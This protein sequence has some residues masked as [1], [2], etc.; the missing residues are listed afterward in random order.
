MWRQLFRGIPAAWHDLYES[1]EAQK[2]IEGYGLEPAK[3]TKDDAA[4]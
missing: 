2:I 3:Q 1:G 4:S